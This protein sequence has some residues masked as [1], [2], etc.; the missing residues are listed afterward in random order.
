MKKRNPKYYRIRAEKE[1]IL[2]NS[3]L[4]LVASVLLFLSEI[5]PAYNFIIIIW[6]VLLFCLSTI[7][8]VTV[9]CSLIEKNWIYLNSVLLLSIV[10]ISLYA[11]VFRSELWV[12]FMSYTVT[13]IYSAIALIQ[14][15]LNRKKHNK[16]I[17]NRP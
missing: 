9:V 10:S 16:T 14:V 7:V 2:R 3:L 8:V 5:F 11:V 4:V 17:K 6:W 1:L 13:I 15:F 12:I